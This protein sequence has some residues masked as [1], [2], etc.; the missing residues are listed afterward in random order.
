MPFSLTDLSNLSGK[1]AVVTGATGGLGYETAEAL[2]GAGATVVVT[3]RNAQK[4]AEALAR[5]R[6]RHP[7]AAISF[8][9]LDLSS[10]AGVESFASSFLARHKTLDILV[11]NAGVMMPPSRRQTVDGFELQFGTN[12]LAHFALTARLLPILAATRGARVVTVAS[13]AHRNGSIRFDDLQSARSYQAMPAYGQSKLANL[14][15]AF[16]LQRRSDA[17]GWGIASMAA[18]PGV[19]ATDLIVNGMGEG[20]MGRSARFFVG[21]LGRTP[22]EGALPQIFAAASPDAKPGAYYGPAPG[23][24][25]KARPQPAS[26]SAAARDEAAARRLWTISEELTGVRFPVLAQAA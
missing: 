8:E 4:G 14:L 22:A 18:H 2:A 23:L 7:K 26:T 19:A 24:N 10:L 17:A 21:L 13:I 1:L 6:A 11:N 25:R 15:F 20:L 5:I 12:H 9:A 16:E 3:G